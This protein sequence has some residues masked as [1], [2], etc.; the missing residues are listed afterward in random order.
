[1]TYTQYIRYLLINDSKRLQTTNKNKMTIALIEILKDEIYSFDFS[2]RQNHDYLFLIFDFFAVNLKNN[3]TLQTQLTNDFTYIHNYIKNLIKNRPTE[4]QPEHDYNYNLLKKLIGKMENVIL[5]IYCDSPV[6][7]DP[8]KTEFIEHI[9]FNLK[10]IHFFE[11]A[12]IKFPYIVNSF[13]KFGY[14][15]VEKVIDS[16]LLALEDYLAKT[17]LGP[18]DE[19]IYYDKVIQTI[20][21]CDKLKLNDVTI[22]HL[23]N[24][25]DE[26]YQGQCFSSN[27]HKEKLSFFINNIKM[28]LTNQSLTNNLDYLSYKYEIHNR[29][30]EA[31]MLEAKQIY[32]ANEEINQI[33][34]DK[35]I[36]TFDGNDAKEIDDGLSITYKDGIY[37]LGVHIAYPGAY[38]EK[39]SILFDEAYRRTTSIYPGN[40]C[41]PLFPLNLSADIMSLNEGK[42]T[43]AIS[44]YFKI[45]KLNG[46]LIDFKIVP[47]VCVIKRNYTYKFFDYVLAHGCDDE[48]TE[49]TIINLKNVSAILQ[50]SYTEDVLYKQMSGEM[51]S[52]S[53]QV[54]ANAMIYTNHHV[55]NYFHKQNLPFIYRCHKIDEIEIQKLSDLQERLKCKDGTTKIVQDIEQIKNI[56]PKAYYSIKND[57]HHGL[58]LDNYSHITS[59]LRR[60][61]DNIANRCL[62]TFIFNKYTE[63]DIKIMTEE[64]NEA[65]E[66]INSKRDIV[67]DYAIQVEQSKAKKLI[68]KQID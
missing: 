56:F 21:K 31:H 45:D 8:N 29:F 30:K 27:R 58:G 6:E 13:D 68:D 63:D 48:K 35:V 60:L 33:P 66:L 50:Q 62:E 54:I 4:A 14:P 2:S 3:K 15:L 52:S 38:I 67:D 46:E 61:A 42:K 1:M 25:I 51:L 9:I 10:N 44:Y 11:N 18:L 5:Q 7:Y 47:E 59:P 49:D 36:F 12:C 16:Y 24:K 53:Q 23:I 26:Y 39:N 34:A 41:I 64:I 28:I 32:L 55:A 37:T 65:S 43:H 19:L 40:D 22:K 57:G 17:N 20:V